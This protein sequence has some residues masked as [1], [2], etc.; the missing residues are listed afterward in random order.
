MLDVMAHPHRMT[1]NTKQRKIPLNDLREIAR[2]A[3]RE[4]LEKRPPFALPKNVTLGTLWE[5]D[6]VIFELYSAGDRP[7][8]AVVLTQAK[9]NAYTGEVVAMDVFEDEIRRNVTSE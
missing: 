1:T 8:D 4:C 7:Q 2:V 3:T 6:L 9:V 5:G